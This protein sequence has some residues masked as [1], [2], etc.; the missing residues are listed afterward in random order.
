[1]KVGTSGETGLQLRYQDANSTSFPEDSGGPHFAV[2]RD[3]DQRAIK[4]SHARLYLNH[5][6]GSAGNQGLRSVATSVVK[7]RVRQASRPASLTVYRRIRLIPF[8]PV[9]SSPL[10][11]RVISAVRLQLS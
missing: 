10:F 4:E 9:T 8:F 5:A 3:V 11:S 2:L 7:T 1:M 6:I